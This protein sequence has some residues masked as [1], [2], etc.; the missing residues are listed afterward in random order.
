M[1][2]GRG[3]GLSKVSRDIFSKILNHIFVFSPAF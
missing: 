2:Q 3:M 1:T